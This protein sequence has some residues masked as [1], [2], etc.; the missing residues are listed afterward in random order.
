MFPDSTLFFALK[1]P[2]R[3]GQLF[4]DDLYKRGVRNFVVHSAVAGFPGANIILVDDTLAAL[5]QLAAYHRRQF[6]IPVIG[7]TG[8]NGKTIVKEWLNQLLEDKFRIARSPRSYN[9]QTGV[10][11]SVWQLGP[12]HELAI[13]EAGISRPGEMAKLKT[14]IQPTIGVF[15][16]IGEA[17]SEGFDSRMSKAAEKLGLFTGV[18]TLVY[19]SDQR[20]TEEAIN[21]W[22]SER[23]GANA[24][25]RFAW[26]RGASAV[27]RIASVEKQKG[28]T[29]IRAYMQ[30]KE[31]QQGAGQEL[32]FSIPFTDG[33]SIENI[34]H[35]VCVMLSMGQPVETIQGKLEGLSP[36]AMRLELKSGVNHCSIIN[37]SYSA[38]LNSLSIALDFLSQQQQH[39]RR[40]VILSDI[41]ESGRTEDD[42]YKGDRA[43]PPSKK[44]T[45]WL[46]LAAR[47]A[48]T[49][50]TSP[51][52]SPVR[53]H[54]ISRSNILKR[55]F[56]DCISGTKRS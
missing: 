17:H 19:C 24:P 50:R 22:V 52:Y 41:L 45:A 11:L 44:S 12:E 38:D 51:N 14:I 2:G 43:G 13:F 6:V 37:D 40:S 4:I 46:G 33:A 1:G 5:Q 30:G 32:S 9:S 48:P 35:C 49:P 47:S 26:G 28:W 29:S 16:N 53:R 55:I 15:T 18:D 36:I 34:L 39:A 3:D 54:S 20:E 21:V 31:Q 27:V 23:A 7:I 8:S 42:L 25:R 10:P 56:I